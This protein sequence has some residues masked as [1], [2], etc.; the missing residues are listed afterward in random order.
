MPL[1]LRVLPLLLRVLPLLPRVLRLL[2]RSAI[3]GD[4]TIGRLPL[5]PFRR[6]LL[7]WRLLL[8]RLLPLPTNL[9]P[10]KVEVRVQFPVNASFSLFSPSGV[11]GI[12]ALLIQ[13]KG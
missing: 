2:P 1:L 9:Y 12:E 7:L 5:P 6:S 10:S 11:L 13:R 8:L 4:A 3:T